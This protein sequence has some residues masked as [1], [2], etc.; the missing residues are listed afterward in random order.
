MTARLGNL[1]GFL[2]CAGL[3]AYAYYAQYVMHLAPCPM[4]IFQRIGIFAAGVVFLI[5]CLHNPKQI[6]RRVYAAL[7]TLSTGATIFIAA[8][9]VYIQHLPPDKVPSCGASLEFMMQIFSLSQVIQKVLTGDGECAKVNW[10]F[11]T[12]AMPTWVLISALALIAW[13]LWN[14]LRR[15]AGRAAS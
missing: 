12:L 1:L 7:L 2:A 9:H 5:A 10:R 4:C 15:D 6:G 14:N 13:A 3:L 11:L 8:K